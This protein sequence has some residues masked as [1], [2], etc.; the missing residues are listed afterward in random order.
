MKY[1][2]AFFIAFFSLNAFAG[3]DYCDSRPASIRQ[4]CYQQIIDGHYKTIARWTNEIN[5][6][7][8][9]SEAEKKEIREHY[10]AWLDRIEKQCRTQMCEHDS[11]KDLGMSLRLRMY[12]LGLA[13]P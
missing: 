4:G 2:I 11:T 10:G 1:L 7:S 6:S 8:K 9:V 3:N 5:A 13:K 12:K